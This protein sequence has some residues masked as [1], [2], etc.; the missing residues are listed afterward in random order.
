MAMA[1]PKLT[2]ISPSLYNHG[3]GVS[4][5]VRDLSSECHLQ[6]LPLEV[7]ALACAD[8][9]A[10]FRDDLPFPHRLL[11]MRGPREFGYAPGLHAALLHA[12]AQVFHDH[13]VWRYSGIVAESVGRSRN[14]PVIVSPH[15]G[16]SRW[17]MAA[18]PFKKRLALL[19][20]QRRGLQA[21]ALLHATAESEAEDMRALG[22]RQPIAVIPNGIVLPPR[23]AREEADRGPRIVLFLSR[24]HPRKGLPNLIGAW[25]K[26][27]PKG[28]KLLVAGPD[29]KGHQAETARA[30]RAAGLSDCVEFLGPVYG[31]AKWSLFARASLFV[32]PT[33]SENFGLVVAEALACGVPAIVTKGA[34]WREVETEGCGWWTDLGVEPLAAALDAATRL[35][36]DV[37]R[38]MGARGSALVESKY[39][40]PRFAGQMI[41][42]YRWVNGEG[43]KPTFVDGA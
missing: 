43:D 28:W 1:T 13:S 14:I 39:T 36:P 22:L 35:S 2:I 41:E 8:D 11:P 27:R 34:P 26:V 9:T 5:V 16:L 17:S 33:F 15:D 37:L 23:V 40:W 38:T 32:L 42:T 4:Q 19:A 20:Y 25:A 6:G 21:A 18:H 29:F 24:L 31:K 12:D 7:L 30:V 3:N 10:S